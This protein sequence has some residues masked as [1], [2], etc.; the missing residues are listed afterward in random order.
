M[1]R[2]LQAGVPWRVGRHQRRI[3]QAFIAY[4]ERS[5]T[6]AEL[7]LF[8]WPRLDVN[9]RWPCNKWRSVRWAAERYAVRVKP[10]TRPLL[11]RAKPGLLDEE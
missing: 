7:F 5:V 9:K 3:R 6:T 10:R 4:G 8:V 11:W 2:L 1:R